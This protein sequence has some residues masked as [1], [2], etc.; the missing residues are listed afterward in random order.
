MDEELKEAIGSVIEETLE[1]KL[2][3]FK[4]DFVDEISDDLSDLIEAALS[5]CL[6]DF[7]FHL[8]DGTVVKHRSR[9]KLLSPDKTKLLL[10]YG[11]LKVDKCKWNGAPKGWALWVQTR[12][13][14][15]DVIAMYSE[16]E[17]AIAV[18]QKVK[19]AMEN[20]IDLFEL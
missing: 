16:K 14:S 20:K 12:S 2:S 11:G 7:E 1:E 15:W 18:L 19:D 5:E 17:D 13:C 4:D 10:C 9:M 8:S 3:D 6:S